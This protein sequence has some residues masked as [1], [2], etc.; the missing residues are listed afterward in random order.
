V[1]GK[2]FLE[3]KHGT[4]QTLHIHLQEY[5]PGAKSQ[6]HGHVNE[7]VFY[8]LDGEGSEEHDGV[9]YDWESSTT[10]ASTSISI[11]VPTGPHGRL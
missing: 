11:A 5:A 8:I 7:A 6:K 9:R 1:F 2:H 4:A 10:T 3:P